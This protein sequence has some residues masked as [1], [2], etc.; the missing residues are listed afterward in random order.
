MKEKVKQNGL[1]IAFGGTIM[2]V[3]YARAPDNWYKRRQQKL[4]RSRCPWWWEL[5]FHCLI[6]VIGGGLADSKMLRSVICGYVLQKWELWRSQVTPYGEGRE[7]TQLYTLQ[8]VGNFCRNNGCS[9]SSE[10]S[11]KYIV[12]IVHSNKGILI[13][14]FSPT[15]STNERICYSFTKW[16]FSILATPCRIFHKFRF[17]LCM[18]N[19]WFSP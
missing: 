15:W 8:M 19:L 2:P 13:A 14:N 6:V 7:T 5:F 16:T 4:S 10:M 9:S 1:Q 11:H 3:A 17:F 18:P 12:D